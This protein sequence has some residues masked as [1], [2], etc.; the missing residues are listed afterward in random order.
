LLASGAY[1]TIPDEDEVLLLQLAAASVIERKAG[2][3]SLDPDITEGLLQ[4]RI[5]S[6]TGNIV[7]TLQMLR[8][9]VKQKYGGY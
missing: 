5:R 6:V 7:T 3:I 1:A 2:Q 9:G 8:A 4:L